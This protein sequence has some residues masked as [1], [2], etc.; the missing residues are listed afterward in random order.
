MQVGCCPFAPLESLHFHYVLSERLKIKIC[1]L[2]VHLLI[3]PFNFPP[4]LIMISHQHTQ[5]EPEPLA[6][7]FSLLPSPIPTTTSSWFFDSPRGA[8]SIGNGGTPLGHPL[9]ATFVPHCDTHQERE[10]SKRAPRHQR[11]CQRRCVWWRWGSSQSEDGDGSENTHTRK[12]VA[13]SLKVTE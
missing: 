12:L 6:S 5:P 3:P 9:Y 7:A 11:S 2:H 10:T 13:E 1:L 8:A 4:P